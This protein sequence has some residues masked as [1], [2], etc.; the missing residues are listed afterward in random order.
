MVG[1]KQFEK[2]TIPESDFGSALDTLAKF[3]DYGGGECPAAT[4]VAL[5]LYCLH[6]SVCAVVNLFNDSQLFYDQFLNI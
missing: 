4:A 1:D 6:T 3:D 2:M 5:V